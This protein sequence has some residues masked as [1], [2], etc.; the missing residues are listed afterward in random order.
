MLNSNTTAKS[1]FFMFEIPFSRE[2]NMGQ[3]HYAPAPLM[4]VTS[5]SLVSAMIT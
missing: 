1:L 3:G 2:R 4:L 5:I